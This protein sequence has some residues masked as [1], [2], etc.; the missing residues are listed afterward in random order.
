VADGPSQTAAGTR[1]PRE[2]RRAHFLDIAAEIIVE[3]G[4]DA[5]TME[6]LAQRAGVSKALGYRYFDNRDD[7]LIALLHRENARYDERVAEALLEARTFDTRIRAMI[8][9]FLDTVAERAALFAALMQARLGDGSPFEEERRRRSLEVEAFLAGMVAAET[10][11]DEPTARI[12]ASI[13]LTGTL[14]LIIAWVERGFP[15][16]TV[17]DTYV[18]LAVGAV[19]QLR[20]VDRDRS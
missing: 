9:V 6:G 2:E 18:A 11:V 8:D 16:E 17:V 20:T 10:G 5:L 3:Q 19:E 14:G 4:V 12:A 15:R 7:V 1:L 13:F